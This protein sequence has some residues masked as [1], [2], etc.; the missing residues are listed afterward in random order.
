MDVCYKIATCKNSRVGMTEKV[1]NSNLI[2]LYIPQ[3]SMFW[4]SWGTYSN[5]K[6]NFDTFNNFLIINNLVNQRKPCRCWITAEYRKKHQSNENSVEMLNQVK[7]LLKDMQILCISA[8]RRE[9]IASFNTG[10]ERGINICTLM[11]KYIKE[12][13]VLGNLQEFIF[14]WYIVLINSD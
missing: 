8:E 9:R 7:R 14:S 10:M 1:K 2:I 6:T 12:I 4:C 3:F 11:E 5:V 13:G